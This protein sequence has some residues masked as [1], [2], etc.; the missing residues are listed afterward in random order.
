MAITGELL[1]DFRFYVGKDAKKECLA[2]IL[3]NSLDIEREDVYIVNLD[4]TYD[5]PY[6]ENLADIDISTIQFLINEEK[7]FFVMN[8]D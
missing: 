7:I 4:T 1:N 8:G 6:I 3:D 5:E 2:E